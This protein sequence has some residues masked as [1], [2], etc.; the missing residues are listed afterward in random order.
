MALALNNY[1]TVVSVL[2]TNSAKTSIYTAPV[3]YDS[4]VLLAQAANTDSN[5]TNTVT[6]ILRTVKTGSNVDTEVV[7]DFPIGPND[8][9]SLLQGKLVLQT[10]DSLIVQSGTDNPE[11]KFIASVLETLNQ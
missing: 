2:D 8:A 10:G 6:L 11:V 4:I 1:E 9:V 3:G 7:K 5:N